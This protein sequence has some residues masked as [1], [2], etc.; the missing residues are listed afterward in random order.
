M[1]KAK[2]FAK[3]KA[4]VYMTKVFVIG[5]TAEVPL[6]LQV[7]TSCKRNAIVKIA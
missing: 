3:C 5:I 2:S 4:L 1:T 7:L 6:F